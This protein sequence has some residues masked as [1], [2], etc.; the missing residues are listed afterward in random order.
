MKKLKRVFLIVI[1]IILLMGICLIERIERIPYVKTEHYEKWLK[2]LANL[3][4]ETT[5]GKLEIGWAKENITPEMPGPMAGYG[6]RRGKFYGMVHDSVFIRAVAIKNPQKTIYFVSADLLIVPPNVTEKLADL[7]R[8]EN[9][10]LSDVH[11]SATHSHNSLGGWGNSLTGSLFA[12]KYNPKVEMFLAESFFQTILK[13]RTRCVEGEILYSEAIDSDDIRN[14]LNVSDGWTDNEIRGLVF[15]RKDGEKAILLTYAAHSTVLN[16]ATFALS[17][18][19]PGALLDS[20]DTSGW[21]F[22]I[23]MAGAVGSMGPVE[24][25]INDFDEVNNL[26]GGIFKHL[27]EITETQNGNQITSAYFEIPMNKPSARIS[28]NWA[29]RPWAFKYLF[30]DYPTYLKLTKIGKTL[31]IG[32]PCDFSGELMT[33]LDAYAKTKGLDL[34]I[35]SFNGSYVGYVTSDRLYELDLYETTTM[36][37]YGYQNGAYFSRIVKDLVDK[38]AE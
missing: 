6:S 28:K 9:I 19:Y 18:D 35:T 17:R 34:I 38:V 21:S 12:G 13:A 14:R 29:I 16:S 27:K 11:L 7:L 22:G 1:G 10:S 4:F 25:G 8:K 30:G 23:Y 37:W 31:V 36:S 32:M 2:Q 3:K 24:K 15:K 33:D 20:L 26:A 5:D